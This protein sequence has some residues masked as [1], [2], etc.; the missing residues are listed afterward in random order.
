MGLLRPDRF[1]AR[2]PQLSLTEYLHAGPDRKRVGLVHPGIEQAVTARR[3][4]LIE[5]DRDGVAGTADGD[6]EPAIVV[7]VADGN[8]VG[9]PAA[10][11]HHPLEFAVAQVLV[12]LFLTRPRA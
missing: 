6:V 12:D 3:R 9:V 1:R 4:R 5:V 7:E 2:F 8:R 10:R 11:L